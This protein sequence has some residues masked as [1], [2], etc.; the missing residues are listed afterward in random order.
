M[1][2]PAEDPGS[3]GN[4]F[5]SPLPG[6]SLPAELEWKID[7]SAWPG[8]P[9]SIVDFGLSEFALAEFPV[10]P[11]PPPTPP[12]HSA[13]HVMRLGRCPRRLVFEAMAFK[14]FASIEAAELTVHQIRTAF[15]L[16]SHRQGPD[17]PAEIGRGD[18]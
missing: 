17:L 7:R 9:S 4:A 15:R 3:D 10:I 12:K 2:P 6:P 18:L 16:T 1:L 5:T 13:P 8:G 11:D 14:P